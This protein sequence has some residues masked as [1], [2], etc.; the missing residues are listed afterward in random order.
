MVAHL[1]TAGHYTATWNSLALGR[2]EDGYNIDIISKGEILTFEEFADAQIDMVNR[3]HEVMVEVVLKEWA[4][5]GVRRA[6]WPFS[7]ILG[8][9]DCIGQFA[10]MDTNV[11]AWPLVLDVNP[12]SPAGQLTN[13]GPQK[14]TFH[15]TIVAPEVSRRIN[16]NNKPRVVP[17]RFMCFLFNMGTDAS[18]SLE[19]FRAI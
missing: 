4:A 10:N 18:P 2:T 17:L 19:Y 11:G 14:I 5:A 16:L 3:G 7:T 9:E 15:R 8:L 13:L 6:L 12:C 1:S